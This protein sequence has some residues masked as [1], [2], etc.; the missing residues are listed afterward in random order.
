VPACLVDADQIHSDEADVFLDS[1]ETGDSP[2]DKS[3]L[4]SGRL[5]RILRN[6]LDIHY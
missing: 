1:R 4:V 2:L 6:F 3:A 5:I